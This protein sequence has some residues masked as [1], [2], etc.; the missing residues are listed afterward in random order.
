MLI[1]IHIICINIFKE[2]NNEQ[3]HKYIN[4]FK[5]FGPGSFNM[6]IVYLLYYI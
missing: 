6:L 4:I 2:Y 3:L 1:K 5:Y